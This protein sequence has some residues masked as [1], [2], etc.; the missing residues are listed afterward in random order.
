[1][2]TL[3]IDIGNTRIKAGVFVQDQL[4]S[5]ISFSHQDDL[6]IIRYTFEQWLSSYSIEAVGLANVGSQES[7]RLDFLYTFENLYF[8]NVNGETPAPFFN[9]YET[10]KTLGA[11]RIASL[12]AARLTKTNGA[13]LV[14]D[15]GTAITYDFI[16]HQNQYLGG[17]IL[18]GMRLKFKALHDY[19]ARLPLVEFNAEYSFVGHST[20]TCIRTGIQSGTIA[21]T[22]GMIQRYS[23]LAGYELSVFL[24]GGDGAFLN[25]HL[26]DCVYDPNLVLFGIHCLIRYQHQV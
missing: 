1:M 23:A 3:V 16:N 14:I 17:A 7:G 6:R 5:M 20:E 25:S 15:A 9:A 19:T 24:T 11:D 10:P 4:V 21:E 18:P 22:E 12:A 8:L 13:I 26:T 2:N